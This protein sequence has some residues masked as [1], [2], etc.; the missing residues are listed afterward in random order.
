MSDGLPWLIAGPR[1]GLSISV[2]SALRRPS[3]LDQGQGCRVAGTGTGLRCLARSVRRRDFCDLS[4]CPERPHRRDAGSEPVG[5]EPDHRAVDH[6]WRVRS[7]MAQGPDECLRAPAPERRV[8]DKAPPA[9]GPPGGFGHVCLDRG[10]LYES[11][12]KASLSRWSAM[13]GRRFVIRMWRRSA[14]S[15]R[16]CSRA[17]RSCF[18]RRPESVPRPPNRGAVDRDAMGLDRVQH[19][20]IECDPA[21]RANTGLDPIRHS[22]ARRHCP[23]VVGQRSRLT[24][25]FHRVIHELRRSPKN[26]GPPHGDRAPRRHR[27]QHAPAP[28]SGVACPS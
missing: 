17:C 7:V 11:K 19:E 16:F 22:H 1:R 28:P 26:T 23:E 25:W 27:R 9:W 5:L 12:M 6:P 13:K 15:L 21:L 14:T 4:G 2:S 3:P 20:L 8:I 24:P 10:L 18:M